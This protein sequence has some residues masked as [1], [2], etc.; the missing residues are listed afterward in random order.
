MG[1]IKTQ[2]VKRIGHEMFAKEPSG[3]KATFTENKEILNKRASF[4]S[5]KLRNLVAGYVTR[6]ARQAKQS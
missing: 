1:R 4:A 6:L 5:K 2:Q 3:F